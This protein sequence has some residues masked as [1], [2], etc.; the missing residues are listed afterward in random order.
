MLIKDT[1]LSKKA[2]IQKEKEILNALNFR[3]ISNNTLIW[4]D[5][6]S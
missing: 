4:V 6:L 2:V 5:L 1:S 3:V